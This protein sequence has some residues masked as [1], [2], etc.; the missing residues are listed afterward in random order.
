MKAISDYTSDIELGIRSLKLPTDSFPALYE[1]VAYGLSAGGKRLRPVL[2]L[3]AAE[4]YGADIETALDAALGIEMFHNFTLLHDDVMDRSAT[5][6]GRASVQARY[7]VDAAILSGD[8]MLTLATRL[9]SHVADDRLRKVLDT[10]NDMAIR[11]YEGQSA[12][13]EFEKSTSI[14]M[15]SYIAM[16]ADKTGALLGAAAKIGALIGGAS[17]EEADRLYDFGLNMGIAFQIQDDWLDTFG[18]ASTFGKPI[19]GDI[20]NGKK[21]F[22]YVAAMECKG[23]DGDALRAA[24][25]LPAGDTKVK[26][27]R[28][29]Y[30]KSGVEEE[31]RKA[32]GSYMKKATSA[33]KSLRLPD[34]TR[35]AFRHLAEKL[36]GRKK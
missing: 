36:V 21:T 26:A 7:G 29:L 11:V 34:E 30:E 35:E 27:V 19:G 16:I 1:P 3:M 33:L 25:S 20:N 15:D 10:F 12:D 14:G 13:M 5:R 9:I 4:A 2:L 23:S 28:A 6:R 18:D 24:M 22:L 32:V 17:E 31:C 8:T